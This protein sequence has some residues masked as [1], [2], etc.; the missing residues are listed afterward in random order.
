MTYLKVFVGVNMDAGSSLVAYGDVTVATSMHIRVTSGSY[1][2][3]YYGSFT[4]S[5]QYLSGGS[6]TGSDFY[7][8]GIKLYELSGGPYNAL[9]VMS[10]LG[11]GN[12]SGL[13]NYIFAGSDQLK[14]SAQNDTLRGFGGNDVLY[15]NGGNDV[16]KGDSGS[17]VLDG[18]SGNDT[19]YGGLGD[20]S[21]VVDLVKS[22][23]GVAVLQDAV[24]ESA[25][26]GTD[27]LRL[28]ASSNLGLTS[29]TT[30]GL[31]VNL[32]NLDISG[33]G[34]NRLHLGGNASANVLVGNGIANRLHG[35]SGND[36]LNGGAGNDVLIGG[37]GKD[38]LIGG[39]GSDTYDFN[40]LT[41][42]GAQSTRDTIA[43]FVRGE[44]KIDLSTIDAKPAIT[45]DQAFS[46]VGAAAFTAVGQVRYAGGVVSINTDADTVTEYEI[47]LTG[48]IPATLVATDFL[49]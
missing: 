23:T 32:E 12:V 30:L 19:L 13:F 28:R 49:L 41:E 17:D 6:V 3:N 33:T 22:S 34:V 9:T 43:N 29:F 44:D 38:V 18:G 26:Q 35:G 2:Q 24:N 21:Y 27:T 31:A 40:A 10:Y 46:F 11:A 47:Q 25:A 15:G 7:A 42:L 37:V 45:G 14:G 5:G 16:L 36:T 8:S 20:D 1:V 4:Y 48:T 39:L